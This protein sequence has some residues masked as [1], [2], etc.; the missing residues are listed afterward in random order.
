MPPW[1]LSHHPFFSLESCA[2]PILFVGESGEIEENLTVQLAQV[3]SEEL[4]S[5]TFDRVSSLDQIVDS[6]IR[7]ILVGL[8]EAGQASIVDDLLSHPA[9]VNRIPVVIFA[10]SPSGDQILRWMQL[11]S[12]AVE[13]WPCQ[14]SRIA[15]LLDYLTVG[16]RTKAPV[17]EA[18][19]RLGGPNIGDQ[20]VCESQ[21]MR[22]LI[23]QVGRVAPLDVNVLLGG[24]T[25]VGKTRIARLL[26]EHSKRNDSPFLV[27]NCGALPENLLESE[28]FGHKRGAFTGADVERKGRFEEVGEGTLFLDEI[29]SIPIASQCKLLRAIEN[30]L[31]EPLGSNQ[32][33]KFRGRIVAA[34]NSPLE[35]LIEKGLF[36]ADLFY[37]LGVVDL[38]VAPLRDRREDIRPIAEATLAEYA[39]RNKLHVKSISQEVIDLLEIYPWPGNVR[40]LKN[41]IECSASFCFGE[42]IELSD[43]SGRW[44]DEARKSRTAESTAIPAEA[45]PPEVEANKYSLADCRARVEADKI[46]SVLRE[47]GNNRT[48]AAMQLGISRTMLYKKIAKYGL[49]MPANART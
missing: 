25:G 34:C 9:V 6:R 40:Q 20:I 2:V 21:V 22:R 24:E 28:L 1:F 7:L 14:A 45:L 43:L 35:R 38:H 39:S 12:L 26:H 8:E 31:F 46:V 18:A 3:L 47:V 32:S 29:D 23:G 36:R 48:K 42:Q 10:R 13:S 11:G 30:R 17:R 41:V 27:V 44:V 49:G 4:E 5:C 15:F 37:R 33:I 16:R 19:E